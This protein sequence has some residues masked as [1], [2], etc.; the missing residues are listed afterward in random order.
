M[1][2]IILLFFILISTD[3]TF[4]K[5]KSGLL[6]SG[7]TFGSISNVASGDDL[8]VNEILSLGGG[9][10]SKYHFNAALGYKFKLESAQAHF[11]DIDWFIG[12]KKFS[13]DFTYYEMTP[14]DPINPYI[15]K[16]KSIEN[17]YYFTSIAFSYNYKFTDKIYLGIGI[18]PTI[19]FF[20]NEYEEPGRIYSWKFDVPLSMRIGYNWSFIGVALNYKIG[21]ANPLA[22]MDFRSGNINE[23]QLQLFI[24]F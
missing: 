24:P 20:E 18:E 9:F 14:N 15:F 6:I 22:S 19:Y 3:S 23:F 17:F 21:L 11:Y 7:G 2:K 16:G 4:A 10:S 13:C 8:F 12:M 1:K 5:L